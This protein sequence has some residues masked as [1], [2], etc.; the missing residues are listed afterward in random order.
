MKSVCWSS[1]LNELFFW[2]CNIYYI[3][4]LY[5]HHTYS[6]PIAVSFN[7]LICFVVYLGIT[8][9]YNNYNNYFHLNNMKWIGSLWVLMLWTN[10]YYLHDITKK[11]PQ[12][13]WIVLWKCWFVRVF[14]TFFSFPLSN[15]FLMPIQNGPSVLQQ[16]FKYCLE[17]ILKVTVHSAKMK[18]FLS[19]FT[20]KNNTGQGLPGATREEGE[21]PLRLVLYTSQA[22]VEWPARKYYLI[23]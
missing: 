6:F 15:F 11:T 1:W 16:I 17:R 13:S 7:H 18:H 20:L 9:Y 23:T 3:R 14:P 19:H 21:I 10:L 22:V 2:V 5:T 4:L 12:F 8:L